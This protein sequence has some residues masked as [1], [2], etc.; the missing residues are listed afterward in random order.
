M[1]LARAPL[2]INGL[3]LLLL[4]SPIPL[5]AQAANPAPK[6]LGTNARDC[7]IFSVPD[8]EAHFGGKNIGVK[9]IDTATA[10]VCAYRFID[11][12]HQAM[13]ET[14][15]R[16]SDEEVMTPQQRIDYDFNAVKNKPLESKIF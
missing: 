3:A 15:L 8:M 14:H 13:L 9:G 16:S 5:L 12:R 4:Y 6:Q 11:A 10:S 1:G 2:G 7:K